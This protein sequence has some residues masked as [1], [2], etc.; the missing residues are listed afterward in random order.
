MADSSVPF[1]LC[2][3][4]VFA[5]FAKSILQNQEWEMLFVVPKIY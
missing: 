3:Y 5:G 2:K 4:K 1:K